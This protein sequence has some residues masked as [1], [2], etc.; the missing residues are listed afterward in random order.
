MKVCILGAGSLGS[1][2]GGALARGGVEV[3]LVTRSGAHVAAVRRDGLRLVEAGVESVQHPYAAADCA[4]L[5]VMDLVV[6]LVKSADTRGAVEAALAA[7]IVGAD[8]TVMSLQNGLGHEDV[9]AEVVGAARVL[10][11]K[12]YVG[13]L[14]SAPGVVTAGIRGKETLIGETA[15][16]ASARARRI[17]AVFEQ[18][19]LATAVCTD[20]RAVIWDKLLVNV[21]TG[22][23]S[24]ITGLAY[25]ALYAVPAL[26]ECALAAVA[27]AMAVARAAGV[28]INTA[29][30]DDAWA[31]AA[32]GLPP[33]FKAS[34][35]QSLEKGMRTEV[36][37]ING[38]V[39]REGDRL[40]VATPVN[41]TLVAAIKGI[42]ARLVAQG[43]LA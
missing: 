22:A 9:L 19:G 38:A 20:I 12:T 27:E 42:E 8:T 23:L 1:V 43:R 40:G 5:P 10:A 11:G 18:G 2:I 33:T 36:D 39:V 29:A 28:A 30:P 7:G 4:G 15:G 25:G 3:H 21:A 41:R 26:R 24:G 13:G 31:K 35:L 17:A 6:V 14:L 16:G 37:F 34:M 32:A